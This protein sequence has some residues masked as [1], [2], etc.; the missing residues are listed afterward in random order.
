M[1]EITKRGELPGKK[2]FNGKCYNCG[3][4]FTF[5]AEEA[6]PYYGDQRDPVDQLRI[7]CPLEGCGANVFVDRTPRRNWSISYYDR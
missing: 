7:T 2:I 1:V 5:R 3:T 4:E 6:T